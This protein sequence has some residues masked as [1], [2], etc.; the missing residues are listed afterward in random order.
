M[1]PSSD[2]RPLV[3]HI[4]RQALSTARFCRA[5]SLATAD[6]CILRYRAHGRISVQLM[7]IKCTVVTELFS[8]GRVELR[9]RRTRRTSAAAA[10]AA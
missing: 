6:T 7:S 10:A 8:F 2:G 5:G 3:Y 4:G 1:P 9:H